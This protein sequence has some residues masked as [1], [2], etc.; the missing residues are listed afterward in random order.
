MTMTR[1]RR[2][3]VKHATISPE[4]AHQW[5]LPAGDEDL[6]VLWCI[7]DVTGRHFTVVG[8]ALTLRA[9]LKMAP[10][11]IDNATLD[12]SSVDE[13]AAVSYASIVEQSAAWDFPMEHRGW[14]EEWTT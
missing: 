14:P 11:L 9:R 4:V 12:T 3:L 5:G 2:R 6:A 10:D 8:D 13:C 7:D 1:L